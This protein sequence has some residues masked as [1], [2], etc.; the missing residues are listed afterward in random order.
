MAY[1]VVYVLSRIIV[2]I[3]FKVGC[4]YSNFMN[5]DKRNTAVNKI[6]SM[7][8]TP[9]VE[10]AY[11]LNC[12]RLLKRWEGDECVG[13]FLYHRC[14]ISMLV[15]RLAPIMNGVNLHNLLLSFPHFLL[16]VKSRLK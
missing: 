9:V 3:N 15:A 5:Q 6:R 12:T 16:C 10:L 13:Y 14:V 4:C 7:M 11:T 2:P 1:A 8:Y